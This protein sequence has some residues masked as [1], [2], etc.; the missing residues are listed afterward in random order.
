MFINIPEFHIHCC[1]LPFLWLGCH[2][3]RRTGDCRNWHRRLKLTGPTVLRSTEKGR[4]MCEGYAST[5]R[6]SSVSA[7][8]GECWNRRHLPFQNSFEVEMSQNVKENSITLPQ[9]FV[10]QINVCGGL[11]FTSV[12][13]VPIGW[14]IMIPW[15]WCTLPPTRV[16]PNLSLSR[17]VAS[18]WPPP[19]LEYHDRLQWC[20]P[21]CHSMRILKCEDREEKGRKKGEAGEST[22]AP[23][24]KEG[25]G[26]IGDHVPRPQQR[27]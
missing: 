13:G 20:Y 10:L 2:C 23:R 15:L 24:E 7:R 11:H 18:C 14:E 12:F 17:A 27:C 22:N 1:R 19:K 26:T 4:D 6:Q 21:C 5:S 16:G 8:C 25:K 3:A 9:K